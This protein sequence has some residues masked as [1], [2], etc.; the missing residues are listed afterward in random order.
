MSSLK[1]AMKATSVLNES[2]VYA[3]TITCSVRQSS[4][5]KKTM[6]VGDTF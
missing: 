3:E 1:L 6:E 4:E 2:N 5:T